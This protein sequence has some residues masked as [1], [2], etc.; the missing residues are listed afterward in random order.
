MNMGVPKSAKARIKTISIAA[1]TEGAHRG[2]TTVK[3]RL[4]PLQP[5]FSLASRR[6]LSTLRSAPDT[7]KNTSGNICEQSTSTMPWNP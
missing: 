5:M 3:K 2:M 1:M 6:V 4:A 7:Y